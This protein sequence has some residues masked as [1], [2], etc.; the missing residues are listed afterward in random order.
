MENWENPLFDRVWYLTQYS[1]VST[2]EMDPFG[3]YLRYGVKEGRN[4]NSLFD[5]KWYL[6][7]NPDV[8]SSGM[9]PLDHFYRY[10]AAEG[11][12]SHPVFSIAWHLDRIS[13]DEVHDPKSPGGLHRL[14]EKDV[15]LTFAGPRRCAEMP[16]RKRAPSDR[17]GDFGRPG[18]ETT[19]ASMSAGPAASIIPLIRSSCR[20][21]L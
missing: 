8:V 7:R 1:D 19:A 4:P 2:S 17:N 11:R 18:P 5:T 10:G 15:S 16:S 3:H 6:D 12:D 20:M 9:D 21:S 14:F 13:R